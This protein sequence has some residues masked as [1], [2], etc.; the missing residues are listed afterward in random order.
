MRGADVMCSRRGDSE[1]IWNCLPAEETHRNI[2]NYEI[3][4]M[5][6]SCL[7]QSQRKYL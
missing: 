4:L 5:Q 3:N 1:D 7:N 2:V 6:K